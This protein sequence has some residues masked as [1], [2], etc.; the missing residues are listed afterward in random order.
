MMTHT[1]VV[2]LH[3]VDHEVNIC[4]ILTDIKNG[5]SVEYCKYI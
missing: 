2:H 4:N 5:Y 1:A 3:T